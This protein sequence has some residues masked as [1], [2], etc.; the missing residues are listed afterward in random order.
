M[1]FTWDPDKSEANRRKHRVSFF[2]AETALRDPFRIEVDDED[3]SQDEARTRTTGTGSAGRLL[4]VVTAK[5]RYGTT[6]IVSARRATK[7]ERHA[8]EHR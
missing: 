2:E 7:R 5:A 1:S 8:Y 3:H 4:L 6:R